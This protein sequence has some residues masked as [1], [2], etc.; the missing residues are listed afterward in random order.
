[1]N[2][3]N[4]TVNHKNLCLQIQITNFIWTS[5]TDY[6]TMNQSSGAHCQGSC[7]WSG[8][9]ALKYFS[10]Y[11]SGN[12]WLNLGFS[13]SCQQTE[14]LSTPSHLRTVLPVWSSLQHYKHRTLNEIILNEIVLIVSFTLTRPSE[15]SLV[16]SATLQSWNSRRQTSPHSLDSQTP[17]SP[18]TCPRSPAHVSPATSLPVTCPV[19][20]SSCAVS[21][22]CWSRCSCW[23][24][25]CC[26]CYHC[27]CCCYCYCCC[28]CWLR[29]WCWWWCWG[30]PW[31][32]IRKQAEN[33]HLSSIT[34][35]YFWIHKTSIFNSWHLPVIV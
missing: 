26:C 19:H 8:H 11:E 6:Q 16:H 1:M 32:M 2:N 29:R 9:I 14:E 33:L 24:S 4:P 15:H 5:S 28:C 25:C 12:I 31:R 13:P 35:K 18:A 27:Y 3:R 20:V 30:E 17:C 34:K 7:T 23:R 21:C 10:E 22:W